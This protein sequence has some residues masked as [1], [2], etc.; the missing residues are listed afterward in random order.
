MDE[1]SSFTL[2][3]S[4]CAANLTNFSTVREISEKVV[5]ILPI[6]AKSYIDSECHWD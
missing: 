6:S 4:D 2:D 3:G 5:N 1:G